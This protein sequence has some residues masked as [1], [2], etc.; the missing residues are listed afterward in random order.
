M[1]MKIFSFFKFIFS[2]LRTNKFFFKVLLNEGLNNHVGIIGPNNI[3]SSKRLAVFGNGPSL[4][5]VLLE[6]ES[7]DILKTSDLFVTNDF[8]LYEEFSKTKPKYYILSDPVYFL[9]ESPLKDEVDKI[10]SILNS[11][12][13]WPMF[14]YIQYYAWKTINWSEK[15]INKN[16]TVIPFHSFEYKGYQGFRNW[17]LKHGLSS[18][19]YGTVVL[20]AEL[21]GINIGYK[22]LYL[23]GVD[24]TF[25]DNICIDEDNQLCNIIRHF[26]DDK[27]T[28]RPIINY[29]NPGKETRYTMSEY[30]ERGAKLFHGHE[31]LNKY[32]EYRAAKIHNCTKNSLIDAYERL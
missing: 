16:I 13:S 32:A 7:N 8:C 2:L 11:K 21:I 29:H 25:F 26:Y 19:S 30:L 1:G 24:H 27:P 17:F 28:L 4:K 15:I 23:F 20:N 9:G 6:R 10:Y 31:I 5:N 3:N 18:E 14:L 22:E 12:V